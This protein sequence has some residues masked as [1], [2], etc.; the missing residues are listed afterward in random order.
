MSKYFLHRKK[1]S[2]KKNKKI[3]Q[4]FYSMT[5][6]LNRKRKN[7]E[8][9]VKKVN[10]QFELERL[11]SSLEPHLPLPIILYEIVPFLQCHCCKTFLRQDEGLDHCDKCL[12]QICG[13]QERYT[14]IRCKMKEPFE[15]YRHTSKSTGPLFFCSKHFEPTLVDLNDPCAKNDCQCNLKTICETAEQSK[16]LSREK[17]KIKQRTLLSHFLQKL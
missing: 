4:K 16:D 2:L 14:G 15:V 3:K 8:T 5:T 12:Y 7:I 17:P 6:T 13:V 9:E 1:F 10:N 11:R